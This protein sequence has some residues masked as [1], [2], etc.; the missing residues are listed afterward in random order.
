MAVLSFSTAI[1]VT[2]SSKHS[3]AEVQHGRAEGQHRCANK[4]DQ[5]QSNW[6]GHAKV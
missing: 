1:P 2:W 3:F 4:K 5:E 6:N